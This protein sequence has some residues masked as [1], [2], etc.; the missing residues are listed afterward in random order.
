MGGG[1]RRE[2]GKKRWAEGEGRGG[3]EEEGIRRRG[4][5]RM[6]LVLSATDSRSGTP[7]VANG[8]ACPPDLTLSNP[9]GPGLLQPVGEL[10]PL[11]RIHIL[12]PF[13]PVFPSLAN[14][15]TSVL[16][17]VCIII[18]IIIMVIPNVISIAWITIAGIDGI[19]TTGTPGQQQYHGCHRYQGKQYR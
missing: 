3:A 15:L 2:E 10:L 8:P 7:H 9:L 6:V 13:H 19:T 12:Y 11:F 14:I 1:R 5:I 17:A 16:V 18:M 4:D